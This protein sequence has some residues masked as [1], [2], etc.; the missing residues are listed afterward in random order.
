MS[1]RKL[2]LEATNGIET[3][4][5]D[6]TGAVNLGNAVDGRVVSSMMLQ[7]IANGSD[8]ALVLGKKLHRSSIDD[9]DVVATWYENMHA[10]PEKVTAG[11]AIT[12][13]ADL[14]VKVYTD[15][16]DVVLDYAHTSG[17]TLVEVER[18]RG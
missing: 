10:G 4:A 12:D 6:T 9:A 13:A 17:E 7:V 18:C 16:C 11:T 3:W 8:F 5:L 14:L 2:P 15:G 1:N